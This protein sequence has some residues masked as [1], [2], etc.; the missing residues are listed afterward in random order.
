MRKVGVVV[1]AVLGIGIGGS[2]APT[3]GD[4]HDGRRPA[5]EV[6]EAPLHG[7]QS[8]LRFV[9]I[10][11]I[12]VYD[13]R[14]PGYSNGGLFAPNAKRVISVRHARDPLGNVL[15]SD[16]V[17]AGAGAVAYNI[18]ITQ[19]TGANFAS[20]TPG[21]ATS[22]PA[23]AVNYSNVTD[24]ANAGIVQVDANRRIRVANGP[25]ASAHV[26][27][28]VTGYFVE[29]LF[30]VVSSAG[31]IIEG[32]GVDGVTKDDA[33]DGPGVYTVDFARSVVD[34]GFS[35]T[36]EMSSPGFVTAV[37]DTNDT[38]IVRTWNTAANPTDSAFDLTATC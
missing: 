32:A 19:A 3:F 10:E 29:P 11:P 28:D 35:A 12:R 4:E 15:V 2:A 38:V 34:C 7:P 30:A 20:V 13:S 22:Q 24:V 14:Q 23:S 5:S 9:P 33:S 26:I 25:S 18:T 17:P 6:V 16:A 31:S 8:D 36:L 27:I 1:V 37:L 21:D